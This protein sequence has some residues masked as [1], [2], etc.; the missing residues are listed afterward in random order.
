MT[1]KLPWPFIFCYLIGLM[2]AGAQIGA[3]PG[4]VMMTESQALTVL[5][6][7]DTTGNDKD[8][9]VIGRIAPT[10]KE[11]A[12]KSLD[13]AQS[14]HLA[15][16]GK[17]VLADFVRGGGFTVLEFNVKTDMATKL[18]LVTVGD[19]GESVVQSF[20]VDGDVGRSDALTILSKSEEFSNAFMRSPVSEMD[21]L[22]RTYGGASL[23]TLGTPDGEDYLS[24]PAGVA[25]LAQRPDELLNLRSSYSSVALWPIHRAPSE[26]VYSANPAEA[27][28]IAR[29]EFLD[30]A[31]KFLRAR[32]KN[33]DF[34]DALL[35]LDLIKTREEFSARLQLLEEFSAFLGK[36][37]TSPSEST[38]FNANISISKIPLFLGVTKQDSARLYAVMNASGLMTLWSRTD[39]GEFVLKGLS[40]GD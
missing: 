17:G 12:Q 26:Q 37:S 35:K 14:K 13:E 33:P 40:E 11:I 2:S 38:T 3:N 24:I 39:T 21:Q 34:I 18:H 16:Y 5:R 9:V 22:L 7:R 10:S 23:A 32:G 36:S 4:T 30:L 19:H 6:S 20:D 25:K 27:A 8:L 15:L 29:N 31:N 1:N 28:M